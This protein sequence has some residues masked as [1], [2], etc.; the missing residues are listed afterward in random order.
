[1][2][3]KKTLDAFGAHVASQQLW[4]GA[5]QVEQNQAVPG[6]AEALILVETQKLG[7]ETEILAP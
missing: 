4:V 6:V 1:M 2:I 5:G 7:A 3:L